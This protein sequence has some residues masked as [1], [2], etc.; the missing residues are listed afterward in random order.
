MSGMCVPTV[1]KNKVE[2]YAP[3]LRPFHVNKEA[4]LVGLRREELE[5]LPRTIEI[6][7]VSKTSR[8]LLRRLEL[9]FS[10]PMHM[11]KVVPFLK[12]TANMSLRFIQWFINVYTARHDVDWLVPN[13]DEDAWC[14]NMY[15]NVGVNYQMQLATLRKKRFDFF[16]R[17][18]RKEARAGTDGSAEVVYVYHG[19]RLYYQ[20]DKYVVTTLGQLNFFAWFIEKGVLDW[21]VANHE[22]LVREHEVFNEQQRAQAARD[23][24]S[25]RKQPRD[26][27]RSSGRAH[28]QVQATKRVTKD[29]VKV[30]IAFE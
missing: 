22:R 1:W 6:A 9:F 14:N 21:V 17:K 5:P 27:P 13:E 20:D 26:K 8:A 2:A 11:S 19:I 16:G 15:F 28:V 4:G 3:E 10:V 29:S 24:S 12:G 30:Y 7:S 23:K 18:W 25:R